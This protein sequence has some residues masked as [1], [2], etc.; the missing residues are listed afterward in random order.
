MRQ[1]HVDFHMP[2][3]PKEAIKNFNAQDFVAQLVKAKVNLAAVFC[4]CHFGNS[5]YDTKIGHKHAGLKE[6][7][8]GEI[9]EEA[10]KYDIKVL[11]YYSLGTDEYAV[12]HNPDWYQVDENGKV[13]DGNGTVWHRPCMNSP[14]REELVI[15]Q[16]KE[17]TGH[18]DIDGLFKILN[19][20]EDRSPHCLDC[21]QHIQSLLG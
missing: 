10:H 7:F 6:D 1:V 20:S 13:R 17:I 9:L 21:E 14:Y 11:A 4:K 12:K 18:D 15:P 8:F 5:F 2:E 3:F 16:I 19:S